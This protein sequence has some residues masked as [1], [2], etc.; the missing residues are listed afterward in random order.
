M[1]K[2]LVVD[3]EPGICDS[4]EQTFSNIG[5]SVFTATDPKKAR[6][7]F[8]KEKPKIIFLDC[9]MPEVSGLELMKEFKEIDPNCIIFMITAYGNKSLKESAKE[10]GVSAF[11]DKSFSHNYLRDIVTGQIENILR[12]GGHM[13][14]PV[15]LIADDE[16]DALDAM[17]SYIE[18]RFE[19]KVVVAHDG[20]EAIE[21]TK[22]FKPDLILLDVSMPNKGGIEA[23][24]EIRQIHPS[25]RIIMLSAWSSMEVVEKATQAGADDYIAKAGNPELIMEKIKSALMSIGK[26]LN[27][28]ERK[29]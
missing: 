13:Q 28:G 11:I 23:L 4:I 14:I 24:P 19:A 29:A 8:K 2:M 17:K 22:E 6:S 5:F 7:I 12:Q 15:I 16:K 20:E 25:T 3:D 18:K 26:L 9:V 21:K 10:L 1:I 27:K